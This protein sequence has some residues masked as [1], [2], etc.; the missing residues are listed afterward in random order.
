MRN[1][2]LALL[3]VSF[4]LN[5]SGQQPPV[6]KSIDPPSDEKVLLELHA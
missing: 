1:R 4:V 6:S 3:V 2:F 5:V